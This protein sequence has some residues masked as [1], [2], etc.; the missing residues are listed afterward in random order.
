MNYTFQ[1]V[2][3][4][5]V[6]LLPGSF[7]ERYK[8]NRKYLMSLTNE[9]L[10]QNFYQEAGLWAPREQPTGI[11]WG[12]E[13]PTCQARGHF[14]GHW[15]S[16]AAHIYSETADLEIKAK[17]DFIVSELARCQRE[18]GGEWVGSIPS[19]YLDW[20]A[21]GK[22]AWA[23]HYVLHKTLM[24][25]FEMYALTGNTQALDIMDRWADWFT[26][27]TNKWTRQHMDDILD[28]ETG[29]MLEAWSNLYGVTGKQAHLDLM[30]RYD[31]PRL[32]DR[33]LK[34][35]DALTN[36][37]AN[38]TVPEIQGAARAWEVS[39]DQRWRDIVEA[40]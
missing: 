26:R 13:S 36:M 30:Y 19:A 17:A 2:A 39:G 32:F 10:L 29:G 20:I 27:W 24:G 33:L 1:P 6:R 21:R 15:L 3:T 5:R 12:W 7:Q 8:L 28:W 14:L 25:L 4:N 18:N 38:T 11:H 40:Y 35:E 34:G 16:A 22:A 23:P 37:H 31:R 9:N